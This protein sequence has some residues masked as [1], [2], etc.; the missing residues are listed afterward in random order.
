MKYMVSALMLILATSAFAGSPKSLKKA[1]EGE[2]SDGRAFE[3]MEVTCH[4][5]SDTVEIIKF[6]DSRKWCLNDESYCGK[7]MKAAK[8]ACQ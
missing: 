8:K 2:T 7:R 4:G 5:S 3:K 1:G 6:E